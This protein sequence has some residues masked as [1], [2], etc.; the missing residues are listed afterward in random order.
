MKKVICLMLIFII[1]VSFCSCKNE[2]DGNFYEEYPTGDEIITV[3]VE[4]NPEAVITLTNNAVIKIEL[5]YNAAP[6]AVANF[7][8][9]ANEKVYNTMC[10]SE[11]R[12]KCIL[13]TG[14]QSSEASAPYYVKDELQDKDNAVLTHERGIVSMIRTSDSDTLTGQ[15][16]ILTKDQKHFDNTFTAFGKVIEGMD[17]VDALA[18]AENTDGKFT[19]PVG[20]KS[21]KINDFGVDFPNPTIIRK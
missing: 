18:S 16:F 4:K 14:Y 9:F 10:F 1:G 17:V 12:N 20:I 7:I 8:A 2:P 21:V 5:Y 19:S 13:M 11:V 3:E 6:N 15:F